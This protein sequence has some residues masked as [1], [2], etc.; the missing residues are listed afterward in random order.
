MRNKDDFVKDLKQFKKKKHKLN[1][2]LCPLSRIIT[3]TQP[4]AQYATG[5]RMT[6]ETR[7]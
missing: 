2:Q 4:S 6:Q 7:Q 1:G 3:R 5:N